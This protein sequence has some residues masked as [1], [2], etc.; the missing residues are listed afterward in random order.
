MNLSTAI[1]HRTA[2]D[3]PPQRALVAHFDGVSVPVTSKHWNG[4]PFVPTS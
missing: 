2:I 1:C 4:L 3:V